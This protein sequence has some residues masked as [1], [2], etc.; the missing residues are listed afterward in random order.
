M[1]ATHSRPLSPH[2]Q[3]WRWGPAMMVS[4]LHRITGN[5][6]ALV[7]LPLLLW[8]LAALAGGPNSYA[9]FLGWVWADWASL[10]WSGFGIIASL[11]KIGLRLALI[12]LSFGF[13]SHAASGIRHLVLDTGAGYELKSN[14]LFAALTPLIALGLT[15]VFW[16]IKLG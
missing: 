13:F 4:I 5:A 11:V 12:V 15:A 1:A 9:N 16:A 3:I 14:T 8:W 6:M 10:S 2:L 7:G